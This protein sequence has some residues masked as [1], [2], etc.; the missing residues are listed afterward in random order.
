MIGH[1]EF[2]WRREATLIDL[3]TQNEVVG[4][5]SSREIRFCLGSIS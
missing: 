1:I 2:E 3:H 5:R 4:I